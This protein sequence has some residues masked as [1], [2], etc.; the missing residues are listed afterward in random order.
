MLGASEVF[1]PGTLKPIDRAITLPAAFGPLGKSGGGTGNEQL[2]YN[3]RRARTQLRAD[4]VN[5][6]TSC[7]VRVLHPSELIKNC[8]DTSGR[9]C[10]VVCSTVDEAVYIYRRRQRG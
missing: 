9:D 10:A 7:D 5:L 3:Q 8:S 1:L 2:I 6:Y 4:R